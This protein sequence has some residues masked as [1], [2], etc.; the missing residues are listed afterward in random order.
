[1]DGMSDAT[2]HLLADKSSL[3]WV[4]IRG[5]G[6]CSSGAQN[7]GRQVLSNIKPVGKGNTKVGK[8]EQN[9]LL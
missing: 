9:V 6:R 5:F 3:C 4:R 7:K 2:K 8:R 1:M